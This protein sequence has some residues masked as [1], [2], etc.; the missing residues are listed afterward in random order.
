MGLGRLVETRLLYSPEY[1]TMAD[2]MTSDQNAKSVFAGPR[3]AVLFVLWAI[4]MR[5]FHVG[6]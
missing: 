4:A 5:C 2:L 3:M 1:R 6:R